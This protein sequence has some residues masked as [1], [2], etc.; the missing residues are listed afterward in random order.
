MKKNN[1]FKFPVKLTTVIVII[2]LALFFIIGYIYRAMRV[3][4]YFR[5]RDIVT[6]MPDFADLSYLKGKSILSIDLKKE[7]RY[8]LNYFPDY[9]GVRITR[10]LPNRIFVD[11]LKR[12]P[13]A[14]VKLYKYFCVDKTG[15]LFHPLNLPELKDLPVI[16]GLETK[17]FKA[18]PG[19]KCNINNLALALNIIKELEANSILK[20]FK[21]KKIDAANASNTLVLLSLPL[22][23][24]EYL[25]VRVDDNDIKQK[26]IILSGLVLGAKDNLRNIKYIDLRFAEP[27]VKFKDAK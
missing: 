9:S 3:S 15:V 22:E 18:R 21:I 10:V 12:K 6:R 19:V 14:Y 8:L 25:E 20:D 16:N 4:D 23:A 1:K 2:F 11:F 17:I 5:V 24:V 7:S 27:L 26:V 13:L